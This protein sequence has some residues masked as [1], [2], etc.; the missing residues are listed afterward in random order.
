MIDTHNIAINSSTQARSEPPTTVY[1]RQTSKGAWMMSFARMTD[2]DILYVPKVI[3]SYV[4]AVVADHSAGT[5]DAIAAYRALAHEAESYRQQTQETD[6]DYVRRCAE[7]DEAD[8]GFGGCVFQE[9]W[10]RVKEG[11]P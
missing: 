11:K 2:S 10:E 7:L 1:V 9:I 5:I 3:D 8:G 4:D 6:Q